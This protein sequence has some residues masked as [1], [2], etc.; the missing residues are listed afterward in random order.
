MKYYKNII[1]GYIVSITTGAGQ[2]EIT[3]AEYDNL[4]SVIRK[5]PKPPAGYVYMLRDADLT[6]ELVE[7][8][9]VPD[10]PTIEDKA[11]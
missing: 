7:L 11:E 9:P 4:L 5:A 6:W 1:D 8:P 2:V 3:E 10:E